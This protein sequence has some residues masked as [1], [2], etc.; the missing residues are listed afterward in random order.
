MLAVAGAHDAATPPALL[1]EIA[2]GVKD[3][4]LVVLDDA[5]HLAPAERPADVARLIR[6]HVLGESLESPDD[7]ERSAGDG[8]PPRGPRRRARRPRHRP[9]PP[10]STRDFQDFITELR[11][12]RHLDPA[13][14]STG[15]AAR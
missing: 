6:R 2:D 14:A 13:R 15:A 10:T 3:G 8:R 1:R 11:L 7:T 12:G 5:S 9:A 4:R